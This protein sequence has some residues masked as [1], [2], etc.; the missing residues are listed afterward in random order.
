MLRDGKEYRYRK[1]YIEMSKRGRPGHW[2]KLIILHRLYSERRTEDLRDGEGI[3]VRVRLDYLLLSRPPSLGQWSQQDSFRYLCSLCLG[4]TYL[5]GSSRFDR[6]SVISRLLSV[7]SLG[8]VL[9]FLVSRKDTKYL[10][11]FPN[12]KI[13]WFKTLLNNTSLPID[14]V[15]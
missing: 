5:V 14:Y 11:L 1:L 2:T 4:V 7:Y 10:I 9:E 6:V 8:S 12:D 3:F 15:S 13:R